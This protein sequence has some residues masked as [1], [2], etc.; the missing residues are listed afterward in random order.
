LQVKSN[1][2]SLSGQAAIGFAAMIKNPQLS[3]FQ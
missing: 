2:S 3:H 1:R